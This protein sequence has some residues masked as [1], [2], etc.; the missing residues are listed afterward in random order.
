MTQRWFVRYSWAILA[1]NILV[2]IWGAYV[3][4]SGSGAG[5]GSHWPLCNGS[6]LPQNP[7]AATLIEFTHRLMSGG[8]LVFAVALAYNAVRLFAA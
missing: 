2:I 4:A 5:C 6:V 7:Q 3:R 8:S 1:Y